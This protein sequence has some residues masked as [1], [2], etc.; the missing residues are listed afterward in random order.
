[1]S[2]AARYFSRKRG[3][4]EF[5]GTGPLAA[6]LDELATALEAKG[7]SSA[8]VRGYVRCARHLTYTLE[9]RQLAR[10]ALTLAG[11]REFA[12]THRDSCQCPHPEQ[13]TASNFRS[14]MA[15]LLPILQRHGLAA[16]ASRRAPFA[17]VLAGFSAYMAEVKGLSDEARDV[18][19]RRV[20]SMLGDLMPRGHFEPGRLTATALQ[21]H[22]TELASRHSP[23]TVART[24]GAIRSLLRFLQT[25]GIE[26]VAP[27]SL[28]KGPRVRPGFS[29]TKA[30]T[31]EQTRALLAPLRRSRDS[32]AMRDLAILLLLG[33]VGLRRS[34][35]AR[36][37]LQDFNARSSVLTLRRSKSRRGF[38]LPVPDEARDAVLRYV[39]HGRPPVETFALFV[40]HAFP[41]DRGISAAAVSAVVQRAFR[42]SGIEHPSRG[43]HVLRHSL[44][45]YLV[46]AKQPLKA[47]A[48]V[49]RHREIDTTAGYVRTDL[50]RLRAAVFP[51]PKE[52][53]YVDAGNA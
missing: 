32:L 49:M 45:T 41:Y 8:T 19:L 22:V 15:H 43:A 5:I 11:L 1:M 37:Q 3:L 20:A 39:R 38:E 9:R 40:T 21:Q 24:V 30:L 35:V 51:W 29:S 18:N 23:P 7:Y 10:R 33:Q 27:L 26:T 13:V 36:L 42:R 46:A 31:V 50:D 16:E 6:V 47:V 48:D 14:C 4:A 53:D 17:E 25:R 12:R 34:D 2:H 28:L 52:R 44:A